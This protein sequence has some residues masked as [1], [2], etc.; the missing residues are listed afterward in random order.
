MNSSASLTVRVVDAVVINAR[1]YDGLV[2]KDVTGDLVI[3]PLHVPDT[4]IRI[5]PADLKVILADL[6]FGSLKEFEK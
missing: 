6:N 2:S 5:S 3:T 4:T 1:C